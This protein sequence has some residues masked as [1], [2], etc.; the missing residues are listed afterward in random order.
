MSDVAKRLTDLW[1]IEESERE[2][3]IKLLQ[4][5]YG[6]I[7]ANPNDPKFRDLNFSKIR[8]KLDKCRPAFYLLFTAGFSQSVDGQRLQWQNNNINIKS[9]QTASNGLNAK[10]K[11]EEIDDGEEYG[12]IVAPASEAKAKKEAEKARK[13]AEKRAEKQALLAVAAAEKKAAESA[14]NSND[15]DADADTNMESKANGDEPKADGDGDGDVE[16]NENAETAETAESKADTEALAND[17]ADA[18]LNDDDLKLL[19]Q[20]KAAKGITVTLVK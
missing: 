15:A 11:G 4:K 20:I 3:G 12:N 17:L 16:M 2:K 18:G 9:L 10:I 13:A 8:K 6:N 1:E 7:L 5:I 14:T 19:E